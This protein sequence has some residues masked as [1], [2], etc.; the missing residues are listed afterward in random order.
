RRQYRICPQSRA[1]QRR[2]SADRTSRGPHRSRADARWRGEFS[3]GSAAVMA[4]S[5]ALFPGI[6]PAVNGAT[7]LIG[8]SLGL[9][10]GARLPTR[11]RDTVTDALGLVTLLIGAL[12][13]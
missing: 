10:L 8:S 9:L 2:C 12:S 7:V 11:T 5:L 4:V 1:A 3:G 6:G 13:A